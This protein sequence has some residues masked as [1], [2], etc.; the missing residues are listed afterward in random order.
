MRG[1]RPDNAQGLTAIGTSDVERGC[2]GGLASDAWVLLQPVTA[3]R[4]AR[5][6]EVV[7]AV[8]SGAAQ[9]GLTAKILARNA[10]HIPLVPH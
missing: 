9:M 7:D 4:Y 8:L 1:G 10:R 2:R 5:S 3:S 6:D